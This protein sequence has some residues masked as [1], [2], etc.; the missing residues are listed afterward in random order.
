MTLPPKFGEFR[1]FRRKITVS[2]NL[3]ERLTNLPGEGMPSPRIVEK[4][5]YI[6]PL[7]YEGGEGRGEPEYL[8][9][10][11]S[12]KPVFLRKKQAHPLRHDGSGHRPNPS[13]HLP[14]K[15]GRQGFFDTL[16][17]PRR[18]PGGRLFS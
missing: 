17:A 1:I 4:G 2:S 11:Y 10:K 13:C 7:I 12:E 16:M 6:A 3:A 8:L 18:E 14:H 15:W 5:Y 9:C